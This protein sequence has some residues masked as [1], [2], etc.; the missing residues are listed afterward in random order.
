MIILCGADKCG[1][2]TLAMQLVSKLLPGW[3]YRHFGVPPVDPYSYFGWFTHYSRSRVVVDRLH[4]CEYA[5]GMTY[6]GE[7]KLSDH[8]VRLL[9]LACLAQR[10]RVIWLRDDEASIR[11]RWNDDEP[12]DPARLESLQSNYAKARARSPLTWYEYSLPDLLNPKTL[13]PTAALERLIDEELEESD[14][15]N[16]LPPPNIGWGRTGGDGFL[17]MGDAPSFRRCEGDLRPGG[18]F[19]WGFSSDY[20]WKAIDDNKIDWTRGYYTNQSSFDDTILASDAF[21]TINPKK[22]LLLGNTASIFYD[23][24]TKKWPNELPTGDNVL[25]IAHPHYFKRFHSKSEDWSREL[26]HFLKEFKIEN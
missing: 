17:I 21:A 9:D 24:L 20:L 15:A 14:I 1:K 26:G 10:A 18:P 6:R 5:Y 7:S 19:C 2:T 3:A 25:Q 4:M 11:A 12:F 13:K 22:V 16:M 8:E 23:D